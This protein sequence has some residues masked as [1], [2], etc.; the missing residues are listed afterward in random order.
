[1]WRE[2]KHL[3]W[4]VCQQIRFR[5]Y[6]YDQVPTAEKV[7]LLQQGLRSDTK[8]TRGFLVAEN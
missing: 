1:M 4:R 3:D 2:S 8:Y 7:L 5:E 6:W